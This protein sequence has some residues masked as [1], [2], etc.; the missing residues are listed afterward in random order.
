MV[1]WASGLSIVHILLSSL[2]FSATIFLTICVTIPSVRFS[3][4]QL[5]SFHSTLPRPPTPPP[6]LVHASATLVFFKRSRVR[7]HYRSVSFRRALC[8]RNTHTHTQNTQT[9]PH[10]H[11][12]T[13][14]KNIYTR[15]RTRIRTHKHIYSMI[16][17]ATLYGGVP[18]SCCY[19]DRLI[20][21]KRKEC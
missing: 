13:P 5:R 18:M 21:W 19:G 9:H 1:I 16:E 6:F 17:A 2:H 14:H 3:T 10:T 20:S 7:P 15:I 11:T 12:H 8:R 4:D